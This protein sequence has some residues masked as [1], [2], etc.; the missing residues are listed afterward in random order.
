MDGHISCVV[1][2]CSH[3][4]WVIRHQEVDLFPYYND[5]T[6]N[7]AEVAYHGE[8]GEVI[9]V[10]DPTA[11]NHKW[12]N[13]GNPVMNIQLYAK[14]AARHLESKNRESQTGL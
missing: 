9:P 14:C 3:I 4:S 8:G 10:S 7:N 12:K 2:D 6:E 13:N 1:L 11:H 5:E